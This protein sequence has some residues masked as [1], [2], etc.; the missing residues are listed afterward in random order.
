MADSVRGDEAELFRAY[1]ERLPTQISGS[2]RTTT[3]HVVEDSCAFAW[4]KFLENQP[5]RND[6]WQ[7]WLFRTAQRQ[8]WLL[9]RRR[10]DQRSVGLNVAVRYVPGARNTPASAWTHTSVRSTRPR[11]HGF[12]ST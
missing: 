4:A 8:A 7:G 10:A 11:L 2:V 3:T 1:N 5:D 12:A 9:E 6:N